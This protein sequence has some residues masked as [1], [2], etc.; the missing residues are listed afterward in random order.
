MRRIIMLTGIFHEQIYLF[1]VKPTEMQYLRAAS[2]GLI[3]CSFA[4]RL[5][6]H[7]EGRSAMNPDYEASKIMPA[8]T[9][10]KL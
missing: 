9:D 4:S 7:Y 2:T 3:R 10:K 1:F 5:N 8:A 6:N